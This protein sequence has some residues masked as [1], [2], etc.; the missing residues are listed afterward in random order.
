MTSTEEQ[1]RY[2][3]FLAMGKEIT[4]TKEKAHAFLLAAGIIDE[5]G[6]LA[7]RYR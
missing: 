6:Q 7:P 1:I 3:K 2:E 5:S 4:A